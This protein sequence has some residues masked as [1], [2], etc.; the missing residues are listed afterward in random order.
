M[1]YVDPEGTSG[2]L[3]LWWLESVELEVIMAEKN[4][5]HLKVVSGL[6]PL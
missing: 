1:F 2:G 5:I 4:F 6:E 3:A